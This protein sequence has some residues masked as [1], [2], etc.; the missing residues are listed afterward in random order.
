MQCAIGQQVYHSDS[1]LKDTV[2][3]NPFHVI[4]ADFY[5]TGKYIFPLSI[6]FLFISYSCSFNRCKQLPTEVYDQ[7]I[8]AVRSR[9]FQEAML[10]GIHWNV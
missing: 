4:I 2:N 7:D 6:S 10:Q 9:G 3:S 1:R 5:I 8:P